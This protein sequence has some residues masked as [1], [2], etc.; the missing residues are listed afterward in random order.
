M[1]KVL[2][3]IRDGWGYSEVEKGNAIL[4]A[5]TPFDDWLQRETA[6]VLVT[7]HGEKVGLPPGFQGSSEVGHLNMGAG[8][9]V[10]QEVTRI[11]HSIKT[12]EIFNSD[13]MKAME[14]RLTQEDGALHF[15]GLLQNEGVHAHQEHLFQLY[16]NFRHRFPETQI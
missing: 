4:N 14:D 8:R 3:I 9:I 12:Q 5:E 10:E 7:C 6:Q 16:K 13:A 1:K 15:V 2:L 11:F